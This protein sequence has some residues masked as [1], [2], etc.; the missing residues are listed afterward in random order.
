MKPIFHF[1]GYTVRPIEEK[2]RAYLQGLI[3]A[4]PYH[5]DDM[6]AD[7]F[8]DPIPG[9]DGWAME[10]DQGQVIFYFRTHVCCRIAIQFQPVTGPADR[11]RNASALERGLRW[12]E[13]RLRA[14]NFREIVFDTKGPELREFAR[15]RLGFVDAPLL[16]RTIQ[17]STE[18]PKTSPRA[19]GS[20][21]TTG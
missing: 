4:D 1:D 12:I 20:L 17:V 21:P 7:Y 2:D 16:A 10:D 19:V 11:Q 9:V 3:E 8:L 6:T 13:S 15:R 18:T 5:R 14:N